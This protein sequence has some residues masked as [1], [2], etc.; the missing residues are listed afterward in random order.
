MEVTTGHLV[1]ELLRV[2]ALTIALAVRSADDKRKK[3]ALEAV[4]ESIALALERLEKI[5]SD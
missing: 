1:F 3:D 5:E 2:K 4:K